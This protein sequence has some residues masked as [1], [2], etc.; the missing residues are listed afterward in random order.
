ML[1]LGVLAAGIV[2]TLTQSDYGRGKIRSFVLD[3]LAPKVHGKLYVGRLSG[4]LLTGLMVDSVEIRDPGDSIFLATGRITVQ[5]DP[6]DLWDKRVLISR[7]QVEHP[8]VVLRK[9]STEQWN[10]R[11]V[12]PEGPP[13]RAPKTQRGFGDYVV[14]DSAT[15]RNASLVLTLPWTPSDSLHGTRRDSA[16]A[17]HLSRTDTEIRRSGSHFAHSWRWT[18]ADAELS[19]VRLA[20]P[21]SA[22]RLFVVTKVAVKESYP[23]LDIRNARATVKNLGD[24]IWLDIPHFDMPASTGKATG[25][26]TWG[27]SLPIRYDIRVVG[28]SVSLSDVAWVYPTLPRT[29]GGRMKLHIKNEPRAL[30]IIDYAISDMDVRSTRSHLV[31]NMTYGVGGEVLIVKDVA[32]RADPINFDLI[33]TLNGKPFPYDWQGD[34][35]GTVRARGGPVNRFVVD[36]AQLTFQDAHV[37]GAVTRATARGEL[38]I[39]FPAFTAFHGLRV[40]VAQL[41]LRT[42]EFLNANFPRVGGIVSGRATLDSSWL[43]VR[44]RDADLTHHDGPGEPSRATGSG[45]VSYGEKFMAYDLALD[46]RPLSFTTL[47]RS[48]PGL[49]FTGPYVGP[50]RVQGTIQDLALTTDLRGAAGTMSLDGRLD[51]DPQTY[52]F[53]GTVQLTHVDLSQLIDTAATRGRP[54][55]QTDLTLRAVAD[56]KA[57]S[58]DPLPTLVGTAAIDLERSLVDGMRIHPSRAAASFTDGRARVDTLFVESTAGSLSARGSIGLAQGVIDS[59]AFRAAIDSLG[60]IRRYLPAADVDTARLATEG[61]T[62]DDSLAGSIVANGTL[63]GS[64]ADLAATGTIEGRSLW[65]RG[66]QVRRFDGTFELRDSSSAI[67]GRLAAAIDTARVSSIALAHAGAT[68]RVLDRDDFAFTGDVASATGPTARLAGGVALRGDSTLVTL[69]TLHLGLGDDDW[70]L[71]VPTRIAFTS[72]AVAVDSTT[73]ASRTAGTVAVVGSLPDSGAVSLRAHVRDLALD[74]LGQLAQTS[75]TLG[76]R[77]YFDLGVAGTRAAPLIRMAGG[78]DSA[79]VGDVRLDRVMANGDY[80]ERRLDAS[81]DFSRGGARVLQA[82]ASLPLDLSLAAIGDRLLADSL[83]GTIRSDKVGLAILEAVSPNI[84]D[85]RGSFSADLAIGGTWQHPQLSGAMTVD[86]GTFRHASTG[87]V[88]FQNIT[89]DVGFLGDSVVIRRLAAETHEERSGVLASL[90]SR[91]DRAGALTLTGGIGLRELKNPQF[92][93]RLSAREFHAIDRPRVAHLDITADLRLAGAYSGSA[94]SGG[95]TVVRGTVFI[96]DLVTKQVVSLSDEE[97]YKVVDTTL[98]SNLTLIPKSPP[99][100]VRNLS[101]EGVQVRMGD[102]VWL[103][104]AEANINLGGS[105]NVTVGRGSLIGRGQPQ[106]ALDGSLITQ[107]GTYRL[108]LGLVQ[109]TFDVETGSIRFFNDVEFNPTLDISA[110]YTVRR[111]STDLA[112]QEVRIRVNIGGTLVRPQL[113]I[114]SADS[115]NLSQSDLISYPVTGQPSFQLGGVGSSSSVST[116]TN[117]LVGSLGSFV[118]GRLT[119]GLFDVVQFQTV[120]DQVDFTKAS[121]LSGAGSQFRDLFRNTRIGVGKQIFDRTFISLTTGACQLFGAA[122]GQN[123]T[124]TE[125]LGVKVEQRLSPALGLSFSVDPQ[126]ATLCN[127]LTKSFTFT[128]RQYGFDL[129]RTWRF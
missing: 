128:P 29:G 114:S 32:M 14:I 61:T 76:G 66:D 36:D 57:D 79:T 64:V 87:D 111:S 109:R 69:D 88:L 86:G 125:Q 115:L 56:V 78:I 3:Q 124:F 121:T 39:L 43:D 98:S 13:D 41:D 75:S 19:R 16:I 83:R 60:G 38:D 2:V 54:V 107:R 33:R 55:P 72:G 28:D 52:G 42:I 103:R 11:R 35:I 22:G 8:L 23:P 67:S 45:R 116:A 6:R 7:V 102:D 65:I 123:L 17:A 30:E 112:K 48:Y 26:V 40:D 53:A 9:D 24:S 84:R 4:S 85:A 49:P 58:A 20:D 126:S 51:I 73:L 122:G 82:R 105:L 91:D 68:V 50:L 44:F 96:P 94:M 80:A 89:A 74:D 1:A 90:G 106:L 59:L 110:A 77:L 62:V 5:Y 15:V 101:I 99:E 104:S 118:S 63:R 34:L 27:S 97:L 18:N 47:R 100:L 70:D 31:G 113:V 25:K 81:L 129:F 127:T 71:T 46:V 119:G 108:N 117:V 10:W 93:L 21:D 95:V 37:P 120:S 92:D 12:F